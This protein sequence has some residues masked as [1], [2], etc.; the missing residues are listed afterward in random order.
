M[1]AALEE[2]P[3][4]AGTSKTPTFPSYSFSSFADKVEAEFNDE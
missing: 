4:S 3:G 1:E 2:T